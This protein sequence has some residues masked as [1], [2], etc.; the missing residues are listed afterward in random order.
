MGDG[1]THH[2]LPLRRAGWIIF[3]FLFSCHWPHG[4]TLACSQNTQLG[5]LCSTS[6]PSAGMA[7]VLVVPLVQFL[8]AWSVLPSPSQR[9]LQT[10]SISYAIQFTRYPPK[11]ISF[12]GMRLNSFKQTARFTEEHVWSVLACLHMFKGRTVVPLKLFQ[13]LLG[14]MVAAVALTPVCLLHMRPLQH[15]LYGRYPRWARKGSTHWVKVTAKPHPVVRFCVP[16]GRG[17]PRA[18]LQAYCGLHR[19]LHY[20]LVQTQ[21]FGWALSCTGT[22]MAWSC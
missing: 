20:R 2:S 21:E 1:K 13:M 22:S 14:H 18:G 15:W 5:S 17:A 16:P 12:F 8:S 7:V 6:V 4:H 11:W 9:L 10:I 19:C 3:C